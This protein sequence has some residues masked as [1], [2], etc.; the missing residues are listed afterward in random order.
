MKRKLSIAC[1]AL[2]ATLSASLILSQ[3]DTLLLVK[4]IGTPDAYGNV[5]VWHTIEQ[6]NGTAWVI[7]QNVTTSTAW[8]QRVVDSQPIRFQV[9]WRLN[10]TLAGSEAEA[11]TYTRVK[12][13]ITVG[14]WDNKAFNN[15]ST[16]SDASYYYGVELGTWNVTGQP[17]AGTTYNVATR[18]EAYY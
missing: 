15:T 13:N 10:N 8:T 17:V 14:I 6:W 16:S 4:A 12:M 7:L 2:L 11:V 18:Y 5:I 1:V 3:T 9:K